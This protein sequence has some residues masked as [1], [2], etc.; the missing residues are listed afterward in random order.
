MNMLENN[1]QGG[2]WRTIL[3]VVL[4]VIVMTVG[5]M[6]PSL[7]PSSSSSRQAQQSAAASGAPVA[8]APTAP[9]TPSAVAPAASDGA[10]AAQSATATGVA[11]AAFTGFEAPVAERSYTIS[12][13]LIEAVLTNKGGDIVSMKLKKHSDKDGYVDL[14]VPGAGGSQGLSLSFGDVGAPAVTDLMNVMMLDDTTIEFSRTFLASVPGKATPQPFTLKKTYTFR[15]GDYMFDLAVELDNSANEVLPLDKGGYAYTLSLGPQIGPKLTRQPG[16]NNA[17]YRKFI[18]FVAGKKQRGAPEGGRALCA[19][20]PAVLG[21]HLWE[22]FLLGR[23][24]RTDCLQVDPGDSHRRRTLPDQLGLD[25]Q[26]RYKSEQA[27]GHVLHLLRS[28]D[29]RGPFQV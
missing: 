19:Q 15:N 1:N 25:L 24:S 12:T 18:T 28:Q 8:A 16:N 14:L 10:S 5:F 26:A 4:C 27:D 21:G 7:F 22:V 23:G 17:D 13:D 6:V 9:A 3:A 11:A 20:G 29:E 2:D